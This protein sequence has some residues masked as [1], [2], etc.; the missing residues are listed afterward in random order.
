MKITAKFP[1]LLLLML[2][3][4]VS[5]YS[6][7][8]QL[9]GMCSYGTIA[10]KG[11]I[12]KINSD[13]TGFAMVHAF[14]SINGMYPQ[15]SLCLAPNNKLYGMTS[16]GGSTNFGVV[17]KMDPVSGTFT[18]LLDFNNTNGGA[19]WGSFMLANDG[20]L[21]AG[22]GNNI[23]R[24]DPSTD[25][26][27]PVYTLT[28]AGG[29]GIT[30][31]LIQYTQNNKLFGL[32]AYGGANGKG[33]LFSFNILT[34]QYTKEYDF[35]AAEG[36]TPYGTL[37]EATDGNFY[38]LA[39]DGGISNYGAFFR[40]NPASNAYTKLLDFNT[41]NGQWPW[42]SVIQ[43]SPSKLYGM[44]GSGGSMGQGLIFSYDINTNTYAD[45][46]D[47]DIFTGS[48]PWGSFIK[49]A[50]G[51]LYATTGLGGNQFAG[52]VFKFDYATNTHTMIHSFDT[53]EGLNPPGDLTEIS[54]PSGIHS[55]TALNEISI[56][57]I[58]INETL[59][60]E[61]EKINGSTFDAEIINAFGE[62]IW[63]KTINDR[64]N[65]LPFTKASGV[66]FLKLSHFNEAWVKKFMVV[67]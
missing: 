15:G 37:C 26:V 4:Y 64:H 13:G 66:Y 9:W 32:C 17:F 18:K 20:K 35:I 62:T 14:D 57:Y 40:F 25:I 47:F 10:K 54:S 27:T 22:T 30:D 2:F 44:T 50:N 67:H 56:R 52:T 3:V 61:I 16:A 21:Y 28:I 34:N 53:L 1:G 8:T 12:F 59:I 38:G 31:K 19:A 42:N 46:Y 11:S 5:S 6:Q 65:E 23:I 36:S 55:L 48:L 33:T 58:P 45:V 63:H 7:V 49:A 29:Y 39:R 60:F 43:T 51:F 24:L 41:T